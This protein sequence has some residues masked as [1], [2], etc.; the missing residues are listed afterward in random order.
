MRKRYTYRMIIETDAVVDE[1]TADEAEKLVA[2]FADC[3]EL[4][5]KLQD[6]NTKI[7]HKLIA[8]DGVPI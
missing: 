1:E 7:S 4:N 5:I 8:V 2:E 3:Y 6:T